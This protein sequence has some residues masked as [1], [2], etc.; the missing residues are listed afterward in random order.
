MSPVGVI[1]IAPLSARGP[2][3]F[4]RSL[5]LI[6]PISSSA[7]FVGLMRFCPSPPVPASHIAVCRVSLLVPP[8]SSPVSLCF[9][10]QALLA[11]TDVHGLPVCLGRGCSRNPCNSL[12]GVPCAP[13]L[14]GR[15]LPHI[16]DFAI[17][18]SISPLLEFY[19]LGNPFTLLAHFVFGCWPRLRRLW[20]LLRL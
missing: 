6:F 8:L 2:S 7:K 19:A 9:P 3:F 18:L 15:D 13:V 16:V 11:L 1:R 14:P 20:P 4:F 5:V 12:L 17:T 10:P